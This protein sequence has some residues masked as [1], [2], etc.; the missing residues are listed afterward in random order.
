MVVGVAATFRFVT[1]PLGLPVAFRPAGSPG[2]KAMV[3]P[4]TA[5][6]YS[7]AVPLMLWNMIR[8]PTW[9]G[10]G[11]P[12]IVK[13]AGSSVTVAPVGAI[14]PAQVGSAADVT[15]AAVSRGAAAPPA[16]ETRVLSA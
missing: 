4:A 15:G 13:Q 9:I 10:V 12:G 14:T 8:F 11:E 16:L 6:T 7:S 1:V 3:A 2:P 5:V